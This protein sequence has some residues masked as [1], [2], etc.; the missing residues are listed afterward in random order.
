MPTVTLR[1]VVVASWYTNY[2]LFH[3]HARS[4]CPRYFFCGEVERR[5]KRRKEKRKNTEREGEKIMKRRREERK[6][7]KREEE[8]KR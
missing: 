7:T 8:E 5:E 2:H 1:V 3:I 6:N 4:R